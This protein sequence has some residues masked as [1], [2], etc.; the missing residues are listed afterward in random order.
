MHRCL[1]EESGAGLLQWIQTF[2]KDGTG[3]FED[4][5]SSPPLESD[6]LLVALH[7]PLASPA[8]RNEFLK[9]FALFEWS[10]EYSW[11]RD[12]ALARSWDAFGAYVKHTGRYVFLRSGTEADADDEGLVSPAMLLD[13]LQTVI[14]G[15]R[16]IRR[17]PAGSRVVRVREHPASEMPSTAVDLGSPPPERTRSNRMSPVGVSMFYAADD[18]RTALAEVRPGHG[19]WATAA[20]WSTGREMRILDLADLPPIPGI[21]DAAASADRLPLAFLHRFAAEIAG[22]VHSNADPIDYVPTQILTEYVRHVLRDTDG[23]AVS[24]I[25]YRSAVDGAGACWALFVDADEMRR[26]GPSRLE[27][28]HGSLQRYEP[29]W[30]ECRAELAEKV[31][32]RGE[33]GESGTS[34]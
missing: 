25:R 2:A 21:F 13:E 28:D 18:L 32:D 16:V 6:E 27:L 14:Q 1:E 5:E 33:A 26:G 3:D 34:S 30:R 10:L 4:E 15:A 19:R 31:V 7:E 9:A 29:W 22:P 23:T 11:R 8:L 17:V 12:T 24:G 20:T